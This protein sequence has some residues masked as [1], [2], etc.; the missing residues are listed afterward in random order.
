MIISTIISITALAVA[1]YTLFRVTRKEDSDQANYDSNLIDIHE[2]ISRNYK[3]AKVM[4]LEL[5]RKI[6]KN[7]SGGLNVKIQD[8]VKRVHKRT[9]RRG[10]KQ[11]T[12]TKK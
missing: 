10:P 3:D 1:L 4:L 11:T 7:S 6:D 8:P 9:A 5:S 12:S 2:R